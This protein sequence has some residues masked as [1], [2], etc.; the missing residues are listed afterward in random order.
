LSI[1]IDRPRGEEKPLEKSNIRKPAVGDQIY[2][3]FRGKLRQ[4]TIACIDHAAEYKYCVRVK[5]GDGDGNVYPVW[6]KEDQLLN[7][8][9]NRQYSAKP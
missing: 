2:I 5:M 9:G 3:W 1:T 8:L 6:Q 4:G 7:A